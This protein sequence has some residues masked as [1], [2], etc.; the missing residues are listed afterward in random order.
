[1]KKVIS[2]LLAGLVLCSSFTLGFGQAAAAGG[3]LTAES[4]AGNP[5][6]T[7]TVSISL[8][9]NPG[10]V[11]L[12]FYVG[13]DLARLRLTGVTDGGLLGVNTAIFGNNMSAN[14]YTLMW[15]D[16]LSPVNHTG[17]GVLA[18][19]TF[20]VLQAATPGAVPI[21]I[22]LDGGST[23][24]YDLNNVPLAT[25]NGTVTINGSQAQT[26]SLT[27]VNGS[28]GGDYVAGATVPIT[29][30]TAPDGKMFDRWTSTA[31]TITY[32]TLAVTTFIMPASAAT[33]TATYKDAPKPVEYIFTTRYES[34]I[35]NWLVF[36]LLFGWVWMWF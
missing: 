15:E 2:A 21:T 11:A 23:F 26:Y 35:L 7:V 30:N 32:P 17:N 16:S 9:E 19:L 6:D 13:Y 33:V 5:G 1:V 28:G 36:I 12:R 22:T 4:V 29:A 31:G 10:L 18:T 27:V 3:T 24:N 20:E 34:N 8:S 25:V 14:P